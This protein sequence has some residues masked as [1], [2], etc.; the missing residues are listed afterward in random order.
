LKS[1]QWKIKNIQNKTYLFWENRLLKFFEDKDLNWW[2]VAQDKKSWKNYANE[3]V[4]H[5][6]LA[7]TQPDPEFLALEKY[8]VVS[9]E[10]WCDQDLQLLMEV[11]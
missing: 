7:K 8:E 11:G 6:S 10:I 3:F 1:H 5:F 9:G 2:K 4:M